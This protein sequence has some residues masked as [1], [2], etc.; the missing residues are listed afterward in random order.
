MSSPWWRWHSCG[1][2]WQRS[3]CGAAL[4]ELGGQEPWRVLGRTVHRETSN[5]KHSPQSCPRGFWG[6]S[7]HWVLVAAFIT[8]ACAGEAVHIAGIW[9]WWSHAC[10]TSLSSSH[11]G[12]RSKAPFLLQCLFSILY[13]QSLNNMTSQTGKYLN[14]PN[15]FSQS[16]QK[17][18]IWTWEAIMDNWNSHPFDYLDSIYTFLYTF[19]LP[20]NNSTTVLLQYKI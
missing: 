19:R 12:I 6:S 9:Y 1:V 4:A 5:W 15:Q 7:W 2:I 14:G 17:W 10:H 16:W 11:T 3:H 13:E 18:W 8:R 20:S